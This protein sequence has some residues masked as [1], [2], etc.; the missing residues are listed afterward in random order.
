MLSQA[1]NKK[2]ILFIVN[3]NGHDLHFQEWKATDD[4]I[5]YMPLATLVDNGYAYASKEGC[6][7][8]YENIY[9]LDDEDKLL[10]GVPE[11]YKKAMRLIGTSMLNT[12]EFEYKIEFL[13]H[14]PD[15]ELFV[16]EQ[17]G[18]IIIY[19]KK[20]YLLSEAQFELLNHVQKF[21]SSPKE[22]RTTDYNL[23]K[24]A[25]IKALAEQAGCELDSYLANENVYMPERIKIEIGRD[26]GGFTIDPAIDIDENKKFQQY[27]N[28]M[29]KVQGQ[30]PI[31]RE[32]GERVRV[33]LNEEQKNNLE[34]LKS[35]RGR[36]QTREEIQEIIEKPTE[37]FDP[38][39]FD[40]TE[41]YS[42]RVIEI[43]VYKPKF[44]PFV[45]PYKSSWIA[46]ATVESPQNG[47]EKIIISNKDELENLKKE[48]SRAKENSKSFIEYNDTQ[49]DIEDAQ[50]LADYA[51]K[52]LKDPFNPI[53]SDD[54]K[55]VLII[56]ENAEELGFVVKERVIENHDKYTLFANPYLRKCFSLKEH[57]KEGIAWLQ[58]LY[59]SKAS[60]CLMADDM[61]LGKTLQILYFIDWHS[62]MYTNHKPYLIVAPISLL[63]NWRNE[64]ERF[65]D[66]PRMKIT[67][68]TS[69]DVPRKFDKNVVDKMQKL[70]I[71]LTNYESLRISQ[72]N[73]CAVEFDIVALDEAQK[74][75]SPGTL[76]TNAAKALKCNFKIAM[77]GTPVE[78]SL[79]DLWCIMDFCVPGLLGNAKAFAIQYQLPLKK[80]DTDIIALGN[81]IHHKL[82]VYFIRR[83]K[84]DAVKDLPQKHE[85]KEKIIMPP[86]QKDTYISVINNYTNGIQPNMLVTIMN[87]K[88]VSEHPYLYD[89]T[90][91]TH[92]I[93]ELINTSARL[94]ATIKF[95][96]SIKSRGEKVIIFVERKETQ[97]ML[98]KLCYDKYG[99]ICKIINGETP[100]IVKRHYPDKLS[101][102][103]S[104][105]E[106]QSVSGF[107]VIIMSPIAAG[108][109]L[110][111][112]AANHVIHY[113]RH[114]NPAKENQATDRAYRI[115]QTKDVYVYYPMAVTPDIKTF[116]EILDDLL[117]KKTSLATST[118]F[119]TERVEIK[120]EELGQ[121]LLGI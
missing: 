16:C 83:L 31:Q 92:D 120:Q 53:E 97:K 90:L 1:I 21:N 67:M 63:E 54:N 37:F 34:Y 22:E 33:V 113:S 65:F 81:E 27:F 23:R 51:E 68:L 84:K 43:G 64:Y 9:L 89:S 75:K 14:V 58:H 72:L 7:V 42:D 12:S 57:Q 4:C 39:A 28:R 44:Y 17:Y 71:V 118:I 109:G 103:A 101:R 93:N 69:T 94:Q 114:W 13:S 40:L 112:T 98:Q 86:I 108:M 74:I 87:L 102:Q 115:G 50:F 60:G 19:N 111:V 79:L 11:P 36:Y 6:L 5:Y 117:S 73:F 15:G 45:C 105:D 70:D 59:K 61:G 110:N 30:Y 52:Q 10:L 24:F 91:P 116:D 66:H 25:E 18:N 20:K 77:T 2:G 121:M 104:I 96:D 41:L 56:E 8:P 32:N 80:E 95:L 99:L 26:E 55:K 46:G 100:S 119:P 48:I 76:V 85:L 35:Q 107:N 38:D 78:N 29:R 62:R 3:Y 82:G 47:T 49:I 106:F 88:E